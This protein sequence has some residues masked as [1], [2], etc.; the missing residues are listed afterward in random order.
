M[1]VWVDR[2]SDRYFYEYKNYCDSKT[3]AIIKIFF[4]KLSL[5]VA[6]NWSEPYV[7]G[8]HYKYILGTFSL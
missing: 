7:D 8:G 6:T 4:L 1:K 3:K 5:Y 2:G